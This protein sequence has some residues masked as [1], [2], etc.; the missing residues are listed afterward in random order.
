MYNSSS[1]KKKKQK[2]KISK[3]KW[4]KPF[5]LFICFV[6]LA[7]TILFT[8]I[9]LG[10]LGFMPSFSEL[11]NP[12]TN[13][14]TEVYSCDG[15]LLGKY[16]LENRSPCKYDELSPHLI[17]TLKATEDVRFEKHSGIDVRALA[18]VLVGVITRSNK[19]GGSTI[20]QQLAKNLFPRNPDEGKLQTITTKFKEWVV[21]IKLEREYSKNEILAMYLNTVDFGN[22]SMGIKSAAAT[23]FNKTPDNLTIEESA[24]LVGML[25]APTKFSPRRN[26]V[27]ALQRRN[28]VV[29]NMRNEDVCLSFNRNMRFNHIAYIFISR[30][31][32][33]PL[34]LNNA[35]SRS[36]NFAVCGI[37]TFLHDRNYLFNNILTYLAVKSI[38][39][40]FIQVYIA[41][42]RC[43]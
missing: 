34:G 37:A 10:W 16:Y 40:W 18:R 8:L 41:F 23:Y 28:V 11:E 29:A 35:K 17:N 33:S 25:K 12:R 7:L 5:W 6:L 13:L 24:L 4:I 19:G 38:N 3:S 26:P 43:Y 42:K 14:A 36:P 31:L 22:N 1:P 9:S 39:F 2:I 20:S 15:E 30:T 21:A 32:K 27:A